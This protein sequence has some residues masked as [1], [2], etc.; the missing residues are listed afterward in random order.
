A[1]PIFDRWDSARKT[2][3]LSWDTDE[4]TF[5]A[6]PDDMPL[7]RDL[8]RKIETFLARTNA[9]ALGPWNF[10]ITAASC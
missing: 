6:L 7:Y 5:G 2:G 8:N 10:Y 3:A 9:A 4:S 1:F